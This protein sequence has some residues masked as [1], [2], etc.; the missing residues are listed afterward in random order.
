MNHHQVIL[1]TITK[2]T[3]KVMITITE[4]TGKNDKITNYIVKLQVEVVNW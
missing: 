3:D 1:I 2:A 4:N